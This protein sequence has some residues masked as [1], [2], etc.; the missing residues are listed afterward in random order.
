MAGDVELRS[1]EGS[2]LGPASYPCLFA[3]ERRACARGLGLW[4]P[5]IRV[6]AR[7]KVWLAG[8]IKAP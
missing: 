8:S 4:I 6:V 1:R 5:P 7:A 3:P 2:P